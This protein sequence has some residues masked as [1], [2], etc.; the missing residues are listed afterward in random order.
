MPITDMLMSGVSLMLVGMGIVFTFLL[1]LVFTMK[2]MSKLAIFVAERHGS[3]EAQSHHPSTA[4][5]GQA[6]TRGDLIAVISA[7]VS[8]YRATH[9]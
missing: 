7:A 4:L 8:R 6:G 9:S 5:Q 3:S 1:V 2:G